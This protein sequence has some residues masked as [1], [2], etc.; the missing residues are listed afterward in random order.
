MNW[1]VY[2]LE[3]LLKTERRIIILY[4]KWPKENYVTIYLRYVP[5]FD[6]ADIQIWEQ[7]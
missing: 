3:T 7:Y 5:T 1:K 4:S 6:Y 2:L